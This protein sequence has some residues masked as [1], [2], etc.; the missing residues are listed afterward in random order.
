MS[1]IY[2]D[3]KDVHVA[4]TIVYDNADNKAYVDAA[5]TVQFETLDLED[6]YLKGAVIKLKAG[7]YASPV[8]YSESSN[9]GSIS[10]Q[11]GS[12][13]VA[14]AGKR[15]PLAPITLSAESGSTKLFEVSVSDMQRHVSVNGNKVEGTLKY[16]AGPNAITEV[17]GPGNFFCFKVSAA[18]WSDYTSVK[19]GLD[20]TE[21]SGLV[22]IINDPDKNGTAKVTNKAVQKFVI[23]STD[24]V[25]T[26][27]Q[28][29]DLSG[30]DVYY[31]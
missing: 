9:V 30:L 3:S 14:L 27:R 13:A 1:K 6:A 26:Q 23:E 17:W 22:E 21:G 2:D 31:S 4:A 20:P 19:V 29:F 10:Y 15:K 7:G 5:C 16:L 28:E 18:N 8:A 24:G 25:V 11:S 12:S